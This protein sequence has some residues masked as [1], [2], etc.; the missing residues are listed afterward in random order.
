MAV[1]ELKTL[2][3]EMKEG[4][5]DKIL[6]LVNN[7]VP[8][9]DDLTV[10]CVAHYSNLISGS[11]L[12]LFQ[13]LR[14]M[15]EPCFGTRMLLPTADITTIGGWRMKNC[16]AFWCRV[17]DGEI[18]WDLVDERPALVDNELAW[19]WN[20]RPKYM[21]VHEHYAA[22]HHLPALDQRGFLSKGGR[23]KGKGEARLY[24]GYCC[25]GDI[26]TPRERRDYI[27]AIAAMG[28][29]ERQLTLGL[30]SRALMLCISIYTPCMIMRKRVRRVA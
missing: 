16:F 26:G 28:T 15:N 13:R 3:S 22:A 21:Q 4:L 25:N 7:G 23:W 10:K 24:C 2:C 20:G 18:T 27:A 12:Q 30:S 6:M 29:L 17:C 9:D 1:K 19:K 14:P 8:P 5:Y 11:Q